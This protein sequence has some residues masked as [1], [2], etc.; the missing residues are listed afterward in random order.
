MCRL[1]A[2]QQVRW[3][4]LSQP[5]LADVKVGIEWFLP[6]QR[7]REGLGLRQNGKP[8]AVSMCIQDSS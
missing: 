4:R 8:N 1:T 7:L 3:M 5:S 6:G 2:L